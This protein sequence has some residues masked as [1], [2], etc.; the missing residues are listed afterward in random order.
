MTK[1][2]FAPLEGIT[3]YVFRR[4]HNEL[5]GGCDK[6]FSPFI[7][8]SDN[9]RLSRKGLKDIHLELNREIKLVP[10]ILVNRS[11][12]FLKFEQK[13]IELGYDNIN[14]N[15]GCPAQTV[16]K[17][18]RGSAMLFDLDNTKV[19]LE[20]ITE[21]SRLKISVKS[22]TGYLEENTEE[23]I[24]LFN[25]FSFD[26]VILHP[27]IRSDFYK[28]KADADAFLKAYKLS[29]NPLCYNGDIFS[30]D[31]YE[32]IMGVFP[33]VRSVMIGRGA[34]KNPAIFREIKGGKPLEGKELILY[35]ERLAEEYMKVLESD[36]FTLHKLKEIW[37]YLS[38]NFPENKKLPKGIKKALS[39]RELYDVV[40]S[41]V[42]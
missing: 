3:T 42:K 7:T 26:E 41:E 4:V 17:K 35:T 12:T 8:P 36:T 13:L 16:V 22:R 25:R 11:D 5:F 24:K 23:I 18:Q 2:Y 29:E 33:K 10:Q 37:E 31:D 40:K 19:F 39:V 32:R 38:L 30:K 34:V 6:Y 15:M 20:Q 27:R 1:L 28:G 9:E 14:I 21:K